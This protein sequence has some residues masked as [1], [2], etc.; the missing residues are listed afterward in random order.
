VD[1]LP[2]QLV[3]LDAKALAPAG[4]QYGVVGVDLNADGSPVPR[5]QQKRARAQLIEATK[6]DDQQEEL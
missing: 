6:A 4:L 1:D 5:Q 3:T 2:M